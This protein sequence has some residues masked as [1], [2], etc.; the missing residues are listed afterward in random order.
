MVKSS[1]PK[2]AVHRPEVSSSGWW[3]QRLWRV[4]KWLAPTAALAASLVMS[5]TY[6]SKIMERMT[7]LEAAGDDREMTP[8]LKVRGD[9]PAAI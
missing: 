4:L 6:I 7:R 2:A 9:L 3:R 8:L 5:T 1:P